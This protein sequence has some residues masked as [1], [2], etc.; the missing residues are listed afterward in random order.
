[1]DDG[2]LRCQAH[3]WWRAG[4]VEAAGE[5]GCRVRRVQNA[6]SDL[7]RGQRTDG[8]GGAVQGVPGTARVAYGDG[9]LPVQ[10]LP[11]RRQVI[12][13]LDVRQGG[14]LQGRVR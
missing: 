12:E 14:L 5:D 6:R 13:E 1:M 10:K 4:R 7:A 2:A 3:R 9:D 11:L 8:F